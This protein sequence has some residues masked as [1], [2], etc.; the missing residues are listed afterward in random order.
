MET[1]ID[2]SQKKNDFVAT[3]VVLIF[4][5]R[6]YSWKK[7]GEERG[8]KGIDLEDY[9][10]TFFDQYPIYNFIIE[11]TKDVCDIASF[12]DSHGYVGI[13]KQNNIA[14]TFL[15]RFG[16]KYSSDQMKLFGIFQA[17]KG[18]A[19]I[20]GKADEDKNIKQA[21]I[22]AENVRTLNHRK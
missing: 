17:I 13:L 5:Y 11:I 12:A 2:I 1:T 14:S 20:H 4:G 16:R 22:F 19:H 6:I 3:M 10:Y 18:I 7:Y 9:I 15:T 21:E 8:L